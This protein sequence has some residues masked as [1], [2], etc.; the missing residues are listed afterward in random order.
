MA[1]RES[2][3]IFFRGNCREAMDFYQNVFGGELN[4]QS[5]KDVNMPM[6]GLAEDSLMHASLTGGTVE[7]MGSDT[8]QASDKAAKVTISVMGQD[9]DE[10]KL[11]AVFDALSEGIEVKYPLKK[12]YWG[13]IFGSLTDKYGVDWMVNIAQ[14]PAA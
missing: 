2:P 7:I 8:A 9:E 11:R 13:D 4:V 10:A 6:E 5:Y 12:E 3:Y 14:P 1:V